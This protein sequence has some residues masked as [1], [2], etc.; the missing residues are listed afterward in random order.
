VVLVLEMVH[1][2]GTAEGH[3]RDHHAEAGLAGDER[4]DDAGRR[5]SSP[6]GAVCPADSMD[7]YRMRAAIRFGSGR[8]AGIR[9]AARERGRLV[10]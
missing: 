5:R 7:S 3:H 1:H 10:G 8:T 2:D 9:H 6:I 4:R